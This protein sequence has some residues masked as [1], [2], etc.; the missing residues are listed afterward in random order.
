MDICLHRCIWISLPIGSCC[1]S[2]LFV[3]LFLS[4]AVMSPEAPCSS[5]WVLVAAEVFWGW[6]SCG[7]AP[8]AA[9]TTPVVEVPW[10][11]GLV[12]VN[13]LLVTP[14][15][16]CSCWRAPPLSAGLV[17]GSCWW[18]SPTGRLAT[19]PS[20]GCWC[21]TVDGWGWG[22]TS[23]CGP[24][25]LLAP[26][27]VAATAPSAGWS[28]SSL[29]PSTCPSP[30][31]DLTPALAAA[32]SIVFFPCPLHWP[33]PLLLRLLPRGVCLPLG[34]WLPLLAL[35]LCLSWYFK[36]CIFA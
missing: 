17:W 8:V 10:I 15:A 19:P 22:F 16:H 12:G 24:S 3:V 9:E 31:T 18:L 27:F 28:S 20:D 7:P 34:F 4:A 2:R 33:P 1:V 35:L 5:W 21:L 25:Q 13:G 29:L 32:E 11:S 14:P 23:S 36:A 30:S 26:I 6:I